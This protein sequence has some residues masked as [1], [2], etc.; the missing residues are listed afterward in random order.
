MLDGFHHASVKGIEKG[1]VVVETLG[2]FW[3]MAIS[4]WLEPKAGSRESA[5]DL[6]LFKRKAASLARLPLRF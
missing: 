5:S 3:Q 2:H 4:N 1:I 6:R